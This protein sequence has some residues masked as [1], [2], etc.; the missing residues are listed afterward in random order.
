MINGSNILRQKYDYLQL[1]EQQIQPSGL[2]L[3]LHQVA[4]LQHDSK[5]MYGLLCDNK[6]LPKLQ[7][8]STT[9][10]QVDGDIKEVFMLQP[11]V[12]YIGTTKEKIKI[13]KSSGQLYLPRSS[14]LRAGIDVRTA[15]GDSGFNGHLSFLII[16]H[17]D[18]L[19]FIE[20]DARFAQLIDIITTDVEE[21]YNGDYQES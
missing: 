13:S 9:T 5:N 21:G 20:K 1:D 15:Y 3:C 16:N 12:P 17:T 19:F 4:T 2:D 8:I 6:I 10:I 14:L 18:E 7:D 11:H